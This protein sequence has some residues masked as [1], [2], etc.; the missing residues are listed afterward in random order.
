MNPENFG[1][2]E[3]MDSS[4]SEKQCC[5]MWFIGLMF[6]KTENLNVDLTYDIQNFTESVL[7]QAV[8]IHILKDSMKIEVIS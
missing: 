1:Q 2:V 6:E 5:S 4:S 8:N 7:S 3:Q